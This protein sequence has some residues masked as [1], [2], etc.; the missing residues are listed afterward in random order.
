MGFEPFRYDGKRVLVVGGASGIG[1]AVSKL[2]T[3]LGGEVIVADLKPVDAPFIR[4]LQMDLRDR[5]SIDGALAAIDAPL[6]SI[7]SCAGVSGAPFSPVD[8]ML[9]NFVGAR[10][11]V[12]SAA[13][14]LMP[15]GSSIAFISSV[16]GLGW[17]RELDRI[18]DLLDTADFVTARRWCEEHLGAKPGNAEDMAAASYV[19]SKQTINAYVQR[20]AVP[21]CHRGIR[22]NATG[23]GPTQTPLMDSTPS[24]QLFGDVLF[25]GAMRRELS[26]PEEQ[27]PPLVFLNSDAAGGV[28]GQVLNVDAG[29]TAGAFLGV[30]ESPIVQPLVARGPLR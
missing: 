6:H 28:S 27:A 18:I 30:H 12:E 10:H 13:D 29:Y 26:T 23:P 15:N 17:E 7:F 14:T 8:V 5:A 19:F 4:F 24:W 3:E 9:I 22:I 20:Q 11:L 1:A 25:K 16:G 2:V 21:L